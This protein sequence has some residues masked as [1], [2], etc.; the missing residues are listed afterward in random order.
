MCGLYLVLISLPVVIMACHSMMRE[1]VCLCVRAGECAYRNAV[2]QRGLT[3][4]VCCDTSHGASSRNVLKMSRQFVSSGSRA[5][6][7]HL[8]AIWC[9]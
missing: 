5:F 9:I 2:P 8:C 7:S 3:T 6:G 4:P 1:V